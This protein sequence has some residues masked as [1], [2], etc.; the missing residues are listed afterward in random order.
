VWPVSASWAPALTR[1]HAITLRVEAWLGDTLRGSVDVNG[2][3]VSATARNRVRRTCNLT[4]PEALFP[5]DASGLITPYGTE[6]RVWR[7]IDYGSSQEEV[8][9]FRGRIDDVDDRSRYDGTAEISCS[10]LGATLND[11]RFETPRAAPAG[12]ATTAEIIALIREAIP[13]AS[14]LRSGSRDGTVAAGLSWDRDRGQAV[15]D[16][17]TS[18]GVDVWAGPDGTW[19]IADPTTVGAPAVWTLTD[20]QD[21]VVVSDQRTVSRRGVY[22]VVVV[23]LESADGSTPQQVTVTDNDPTSPTYVGGPFGRIPRF[24]R[25]P[26][27][28]T[29]AQAQTA[30]RALL[31]RSTSL[32]RTRVVTC[33]PN[34]TLEVGDRVDL[35]VGGQLEQHVVDTF[36]L[37]LATDS[38]AMS[39]TTRLATPDPGDEES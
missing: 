33:V 26:L 19:Y 27:V 5:T 39:I 13:G 9:V 7:G 12:I 35:V 28:K 20:G 16:L 32:T 14:I 31:A 29:I 36:T 37:P 38:P 17:A 2:G 23:V 11:A 18:I 6:I 10:D 1:S 34:P 3:T 4:V 15:D 8:P 30:G 21:G 24:Y 25:S 22:S